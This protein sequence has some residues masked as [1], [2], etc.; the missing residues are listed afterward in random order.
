MS[1]YNFEEEDALKTKMDNE[2]VLVNSEKDWFVVYVDGREV[3]SY[4]HKK[5]AEEAA[6]NLRKMLIQNFNF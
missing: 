3:D 1:K 2:R 4:K 6:A 5:G